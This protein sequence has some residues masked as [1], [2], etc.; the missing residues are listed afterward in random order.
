MGLHA[1]HTSSYLLFSQGSEEFCCMW[2][3]LTQQHTKACSFQGLSPFWCRGRN[4]S[5]VTDMATTAVPSLS[6]ATLPQL[7]AQ[8]PLIR[9]LPQLDCTWGTPGLGTGPLVSEKASEQVG[10]NPTGHEKRVSECIRWVSLS[11]C[12]FSSRLLTIFVEA[13]SPP[14]LL[15]STTSNQS[16]PSAGQSHLQL[17]TLSCWLTISNTYAVVLHCILTVVLG[18]HLRATPLVHKLSFH[19]F[20][21]YFWQGF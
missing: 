15:P 2:G 11:P 9:V 18:H 10:V 14:A 17:Q 16:L 20:R 8:V 6:R 13:S 21:M 4:K 7:L 1:T 5:R 19:P 12:L 3:R